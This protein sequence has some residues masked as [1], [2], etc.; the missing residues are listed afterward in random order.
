MDFE[1]RLEKAIERGKHQSAARAQ[2]EARKALTERELRRLHGQYRLDLSERIENCLAQLVDHFPGFRLETVV[3]QR[4]WGAAV[5]RDDLELSSDRSRT[6]SFSRL[7]IVVRPFSEANLLELVAKGTVRNRE[8]FNRS[9]YQRLGEADL[10][11]FQNVIDLWVLEFAET[12]ASEDYR[13]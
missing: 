12:Y 8:V 13:A 1:K 6:S 7:E 2:A 4:G 10:T 9:Q 5:G 3:D 11:S